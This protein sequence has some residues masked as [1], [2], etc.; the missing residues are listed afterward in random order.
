M[1]TKTCADLLQQEA[2]LPGIITFCK[3]LDHAIGHSGVSVGLITEFC[4]PPGSGKTQMCLQLCVNANLPSELGGL[5]G[6]SLYLD[7]NFGFS[8]DR[9]REIATACVQHCQRIVRTSRPQLAEVTSKFT[10]E[11]IV[12]SV[13]YN[14]VHVCN[15]LTK[16]IDTLERL[17]KLGEKIRLVVIDS[18]SFLIRCNIENTLERIRIDHTVLNRLQILAQ[19]FKFAIVLT[20]D[21]TTKLN[22]TEPSTIA[23]ALGDSHGHRINQRIVLGQTGSE[24]GMFVASVEKGFHRP[25]MAVKFQISSAGVRGVRKK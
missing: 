18:Y 4:G 12:E 14:H 19:Q 7:T 25:R 8:P 6:K 11:S 21:V 1:F 24:P 13:L 20:N 16:S 10:A 15:D 17:L 5:G 3:D 22:G 2:R 23:P 9:L